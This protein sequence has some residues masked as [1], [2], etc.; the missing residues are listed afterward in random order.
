MATCSAK[1]FT[2][3]DMVWFYVLGSDAQ[4][5]GPFHHIHIL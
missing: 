1:I 2:P 5:W 4:M 3:Q